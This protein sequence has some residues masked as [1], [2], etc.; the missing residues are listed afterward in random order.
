VI[1]QVVSQRKTFCYGKT[2]Q[3]WL[4]LGLPTFALP[5]HTIMQVEC[6]SVCHTT[7]TYFFSGW[8]LFVK[9]HVKDELGG[10][11]K[12]DK[13][14]YKAK[15]LRIRNITLAGSSCTLIFQAEG[16]IKSA[17]HCS[18][19]TERSVILS[20]NTFMITVQITVNLC[21]ED[22]L[23]LASMLRTC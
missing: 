3:P 15:F 14:I 21:K 6:F 20:C 7:V 18:T 13:G 10:H 19:V 23:Y 5:E 17:K 8:K 22:Y 12:G 11:M 4:S 1:P 16:V 9:H 2:L